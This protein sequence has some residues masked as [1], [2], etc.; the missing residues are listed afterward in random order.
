MR[1]GRQMVV[2]E[3]SGQDPHARLQAIIDCIQGYLFNCSSSWL[4]QCFAKSYYHKCSR[5]WTQVNIHIEKF[6]L[7]PKLNYSQLKDVIELER[8]KFPTNS[9][10]GKQLK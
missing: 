8:Q 7:D 9:Y 5:S 4:F 1:Q 10:Y 2:V 3:F 6:L